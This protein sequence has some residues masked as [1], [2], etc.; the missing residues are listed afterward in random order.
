MTCSKLLVRL[1]RLIVCLVSVFSFSILAY[2]HMSSF[3]KL[4]CFRKE[5]QPVIDIEINSSIKVHPEL[6]FLIPCN[7]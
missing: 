4:H 1:V 5:M 7:K 6:L 2:L 3:L